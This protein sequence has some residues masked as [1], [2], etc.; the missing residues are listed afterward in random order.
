MSESKIRD[1][2]IAAC[3]RALEPLARIL[4]RAGFSYEDFGQVSQ[5]AFV[6]VAPEIFGDSDESEHD[7]WVSEL[8][9]I[10][11]ERVAEL[12]KEPH[13]DS[14]S[15]T[16]VTASPAAV[17]HFWY[18]DP[19]YL[20]PETRL[21][22]HLSYS[23]GDKCF[24]LLAE[25]YGGGTPSGELI[26]QLIRAGAV[27]VD[28]ENRFFPTEKIYFGATTDEPL[29]AA[30]GSHL[31]FFLAAAEENAKPGYVR[32]KGKFER[33]VTTAVPKEKMEEVRKI[34]RDSV[35]TYTE[36][37]DN[38]LSQYETDDVVEIK[39]SDVLVGLGVYEIVGSQ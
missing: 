27:D 24:V 39:E 10:D 3:Q 37:L 33:I 32:G 29:L 19:D 26:K 16:G 5:K 38:D 20:D 36:Q 6:D 23:S 8:T 4:L 28:E 31:Y 9:G 18:E 22:L 2:L 14:I 34:I 35:T 1:Q 11:E 12:R 7:S 17:L 21:P 30:I 13:Q 15:E 25:K